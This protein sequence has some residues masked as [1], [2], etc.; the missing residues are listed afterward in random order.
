MF[1]VD[2]SRVGRLKAV[3]G[4]APGFGPTDEFV[5]L[6]GKT[7]E[8]E[9][10][11]QVTGQDYRSIE[12]PAKNSGSD[13]IEEVSED[14]EDTFKYSDELRQKRVELDRKLQLHPHDIDIWLE[15]LVLQD[16]I[17]AGQKASTADIKIGIIQKALT[18]NPGNTKLFVELFK[19]EAILWEYCQYLSQLIIGRREFLHIGKKF[20]RNMKIRN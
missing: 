7:E 1:A 11:A 19:L 12:G 14:D 13:D 6:S 15:Y 16:D 17:G 18:K 9:T 5:P 8:K 20:F 2:S 10:E 3:D 4:V